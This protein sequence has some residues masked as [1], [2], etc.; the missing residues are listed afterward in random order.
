MYNYIYVCMEIACAELFK[1]YRA[2]LRIS[3]ITEACR[4]CL[5]EYIFYMYISISICLLYNISQH[6][7]GRCAAIFVSSNYQSDRRNSMLW[8]GLLNLPQHSINWDCHSPFMS[9][10]LLFER[11]IFN[12]T[13]TY[14]HTCIVA[15]LMR[16]N[17][18]VEL[19]EFFY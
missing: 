16:R 1:V 2:F 12:V 17:N 13:Y 9:V 3:K 19:H 5:I 7:I 15:K 18:L 8:L 6:K 14:I 11:A 4:F 10:P